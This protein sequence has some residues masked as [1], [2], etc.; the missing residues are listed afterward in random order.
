MFGP[1]DYFMFSVFAVLILA[2][3]IRPAREFPAV[4]G[5]KLMGTLAAAMYWAI[6]TYSPFLWDAWLGAHRL[7]DATG[8]PIYVS[9]VVALL[10]Y[11]LGIYVWHRT[12]H[13]TPFLWRWFHQTHHSAERIDVWGALYFHPLDVL[14]FAFVGS[15]MLVLV[16]GFEPAAVMFAIF[17]STFCGLFQ[18]ANLKTPR[19]LGYIITRPESHALHHQ[20]GVHRYNYGDIPFWDMIFGT[21][22]NPPTWHAKAGLVDGGSRKYLALLLG[23]DIAKPSPLP[24]AD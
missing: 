12:M 22:R 20:R 2:E 14:G 6:A 17:V 13:V 23:R 16:A 18:H 3:S 10:T 5:W 4:R 7:I 8:L 21:F 15:L 19:W 1:L 24:N 11:Q 9:A